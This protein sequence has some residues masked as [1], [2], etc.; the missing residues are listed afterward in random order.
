MDEIDNFTQNSMRITVMWSKSKPEEEFQ[1]GKRLFLQNGNNYISAV[2]WVIL[3][4][5]GVL[6]DI[7]FLK[8]VTSPYLKP[9][10]K[11]RLSGRH[12][13]KR[14]GVRREWSDIGDMCHA[15]TEWHGNY[16]DEVE[17][18][19]FD[20]LKMNW[21]RKIAHWSGMLFQCKS[22]RFRRSWT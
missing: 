3:T 4:I 17:T 18:E 7:D 21:K 22:V 10:V 11:L 20:G 12:L 9:K 2:D 14:W 8:K 15:D 1:Y 6:I 13:K 5:F 19:K 16:G